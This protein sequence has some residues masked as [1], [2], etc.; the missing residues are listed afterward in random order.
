MKS[1]AGNTRS[2]LAS[3]ADKP[4]SMLYIWQAGGVVAAM[5]T[6]TTVCSRHADAKEHS[7]L[8]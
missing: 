6:T 8:S 4:L 1:I 7:F 3:L 2:L 5:P